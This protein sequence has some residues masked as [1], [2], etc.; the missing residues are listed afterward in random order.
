MKFEWKG[1]FPAITTQ[2]TA[3]DQLDIQMFGKNL[4]AQ[5]EAGIHGVILGGTLGES[6]TLS[7]E[8]K[9]M[10]IRFTKE[11]VAG[12]IPVILNIA[13]GAT[14]AAVEEAQWAEQLGVDGLMLLPPMRYKANDRETVVFFRAVAHAVQLPIMIY[15]NPVDYRIMVTTDMFEQLADCENIQ[16]V[17]DSTRDVSNVTRM[18]NQFGN[19]Y[20]ILCGVDTIAMESM[21]MGA[22]GWVGGLVNAFPRETVLLYHL[23]QSRQIDK[24]LEVHRWFLPLLELDLSPKLVQYIKLAA[25]VTGIGAEHVRPPRLPLI[26]G[27]RQ[28]ILSLIQKAVAAEPGWMHDLQLLHETAATIRS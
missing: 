11:K 22:S 16:A 14:K 27:E 20:R 5:L 21:L 12:R 4:S 6:S 18:I 1:V 19:R 26:G 2:F 23:V 17:K 15:N 3:D 7:R 10:L 24:A 9:E 28:Q 13:E 25:S 8:E